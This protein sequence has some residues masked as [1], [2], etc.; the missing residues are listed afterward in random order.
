[1]KNHLRTYL[2]GL[3]GGSVISERMFE[4]AIN[5]VDKNYH[6]YFNN[7]KDR[8]LWDE[9]YKLLSKNPD[10]LVANLTYFDVC[11]EFYDQDRAM[12]FILDP[13]FRDSQYF[14]YKYMNTRP[15]IGS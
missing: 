5:W 14:M 9:T 12:K 6:L 10:N 8:K 11:L 15:K 1:M 4:D 3:K 7:F 13:L 2:Y